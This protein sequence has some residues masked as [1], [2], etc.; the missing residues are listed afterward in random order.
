L[1]GIAF[2]YATNVSGGFMVVVCRKTISLWEHVRWHHPLTGCLCPPPGE[3]RGVYEGACDCR[4]LYL[5]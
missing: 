2:V 3:L 5:I 1:T 4:K